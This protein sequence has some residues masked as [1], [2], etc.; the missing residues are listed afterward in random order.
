MRPPSFEEFYFQTREN[1][2]ETRRAHA[3]GITWRSVTRLGNFYKFLGNKL[4]HK[5]NPSNLVTFGVFLVMSLFC[6]KC[7]GRL[8]GHFLLHYLVTLLG[9]EVEDKRCG[10]LG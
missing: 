9:G 3:H 10:L 4:S 8:F 2:A 6:K 5:S 1:F 7:V